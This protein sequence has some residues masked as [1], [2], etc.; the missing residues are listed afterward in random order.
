MPGETKRSFPEWHK[1]LLRLEGF[2]A[3]YIH[4]VI[5]LSRNFAGMRE[6]LEKWVNEG[7]TEEGCRITLAI[8]DLLGKLSTKAVEPTADDDDGT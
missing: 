3:G 5:Y 2:P 8:D 7:P 1:H 6:L 4:Q